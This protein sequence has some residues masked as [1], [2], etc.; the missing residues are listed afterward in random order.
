VHAEPSEQVR[1]VMDSVRRSNT[2]LHSERL[3]Y[4]ILLENL[5][6]WT[7]VAHMT[8]DDVES[9]HDIALQLC[10]HSQRF[11]MYLFLIHISPNPV[12]D[13]KDDVLLRMSSTRARLGLMQRRLSSKRDILRAISANAFPLLGA[14]GHTYLRDTT[15]HLNDLLRTVALARDSLNQL[16][17]NYLAK[18]SLDLA[19]TDKENNRSMKIFSVIATVGLPVNAISGIGIPNK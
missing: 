7:P 5:R 11:L 14:R 15:D 16:Q 18:I 6:L 10:A 17:S 9:L 4:L 2:P 8:E 19:E 12:S 3:L 1:H 13:N